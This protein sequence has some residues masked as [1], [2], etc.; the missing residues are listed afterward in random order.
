MPQPFPESWLLKNP[1]AWQTPSVARFV[2][3]VAAKYN[4]RY[5]PDLEKRLRDVA[6]LPAPKLG[7]PP[8]LP[9]PVPPPSRIKPKPPPPLP[10]EL[11]S[12]DRQSRAAGDSD[13]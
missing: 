10:P 3:T 11:P 5:T 4:H 2:L 1:D 7:D 13:A 8:R 12:I 6:G 9:R